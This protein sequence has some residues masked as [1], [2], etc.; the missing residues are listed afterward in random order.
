MNDSCVIFLVWCHLAD[1]L[2]EVATATSSPA[3]LTGVCVQRWHI[4]L[5]AGIFGAL[6]LFCLSGDLN[7]IHLD[8]LRHPL[9]RLGQTLHAQVLTAEAE[10]SDPGP[11]G[12]CVST[13]SRLVTC[14]SF[15]CSAFL[16]W[17]RISWLTFFFALMSPRRT[18]MYFWV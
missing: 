17:A 11:C 12:L 8:L 1:R 7:F 15:S 4:Y 16:F 9:Q 2:H 10:T 14:C 18:S 3:V 6:F 13:L 5:Q